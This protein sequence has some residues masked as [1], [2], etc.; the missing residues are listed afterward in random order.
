[1]T[2]A[3]PLG[4]IG[5]YTLHPVRGQVEVWRDSELVGVAFSAVVA[6][7]EGRW[8]GRKRGED[9]VPFN[10]RSEAVAHIVGCRPEDVPGGDID[11]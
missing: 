7:P 6:K 1:M 9:A 5:G 8:Y 11:G 10:T 2:A 4:T 3:E